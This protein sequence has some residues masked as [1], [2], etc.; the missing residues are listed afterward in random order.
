MPCA[1]WALPANRPSDD[2]QPLEGEAED[3]HEPEGREPVGDAAVQAEA[4]READRDGDGEASASMAVSAIA[5]PASTE[6]RGIGS[7]RSRS[8]KPC[9]M[10]SAMPAACRC[11]RTGRWWR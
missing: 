11:R 5:R 6:L 1:A 10:S 2:E 9:S 7:E 8:M 4:D 3:D